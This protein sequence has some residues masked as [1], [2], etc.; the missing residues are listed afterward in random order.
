MTVQA[1]EI[2]LKFTETGIIGHE[3]EQ[4]RV[5][6]T[7]VIQE[8]YGYEVKKSVAFPE[9]DSLFSF[10]P[11]EMF[12]L[13]VSTLTKKP[14]KKYSVSKDKKLEFIYYSLHKEDLPALKLSLTEKI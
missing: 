4:S 13:S 2:E 10:N 7:E 5:V 12:F 1:L 3:S 6:Q 14:L 9:I 11:E 8:L